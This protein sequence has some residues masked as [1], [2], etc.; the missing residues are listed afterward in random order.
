MNLFE[1]IALL[2]G[3]SA[4]FAYLNARFLRLPTTIGVM[5]IALAFSLALVAA[6]ALGFPGLTDWAERAVTAVDFDRT[7]L[8]AMLSMLLFAGALHV[9]LDEL[10]RQWRVIGL[11]ATVGVVVGTTVIGAA[12]YTV[13]GLLG[14]GIPF[15]YCLLFAAVIAPTDPVA[16]LGIVRKLGLPHALQTKIAGESLFND[17][18]AIVV[19]LGLAGIASGETEGAGAVAIL[20]AEEVFGGIALGLLL[21]A[22]GYWLLR[23]L[24]EYVVEVLITLALVIGGYA[25]ALRWHFSGPLAVVVAGLLL[26]NHGRRFAMSETTRIH[27]YTFWELVDEVLNIILFLVIGLEVLV[28]PFEPQPVMLGLVVIPLVLLA[29]FLAVGGVIYAL[30]PLRDFDRGVVRILTWGG[31]RGGISVALALSLP[32]SPEREIIVTMTYIVVVFSVLVQGLTVAPLVQR[33][34]DK[35]SRG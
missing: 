15:I 25:L 10:G 21:G 8:D 24:D 13:Q 14:V 23:S 26:G 12:T 2:L 22:M 34:R 16:V 20:F 4:T 6:Q 7:L 31:L 19:F 29:R 17:G 35:E 5:A 28:I 33:L 30:S 32:D 27:L 9:L 1:L 11:L 18:F 3:L